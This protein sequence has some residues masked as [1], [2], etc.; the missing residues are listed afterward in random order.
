MNPEFAADF[1]A[2]VAKL[3]ELTTGDTSPEMID[4]IKI[5][6]IYNHIHKS[7]PALAAHWSQAHPGARAEVRK[8]FEEIRD[9]NRA[10]RKSD[11]E[12]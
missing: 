4:K 8:L 12:E 5:W 1:D 2:L 7:M 3:A 10:L 11:G 9:K 6:A